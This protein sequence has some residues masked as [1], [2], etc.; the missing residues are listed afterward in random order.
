MVNR[1]INLTKSNSFFLFGPRQTGKSTLLQKQ[2]PE[3]TLN[4]NLLS[5][6]TY[7]RLAARPG[8][9]KEEIMAA[10]RERTI[11]HVII[12]EVQRIPALLDEVHSMLE[13]AEPCVF[14][15][16]GSSA[17]KLKRTH[18]NMLG[19]RAWTYRLFPLTTQEIGAGFNLERALH[20]GTLPKVYLA[21]TDMERSEILRSYV[22]TYIR[23]E[24]EIEAQIRNIGGF[25]RFLPTIASENGALVNFLNLSREL[26]LSVSTIRS[27]YQIMEDTLLGFFLSPMAK[28]ARKMAAGHPR[29]YLFDCGVVRALQKKLNAPLDEKTEEY[30]RAFEHFFICEIMRL[31]TYLRL[32]LDISFYRT[33]RGA[34]VDCIIKAP[35]G[36]LTA[37]EIKSTR[38][39]SPHHCSGLRS[40]REI[41]PDAKC[42]LACK[43]DKS[44][45]I[46]DVLALPWQEALEKIVS[47]K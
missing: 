45:V 24:I 5:T 46:G 19:G 47:L 23:E 14:G 10:R 13:S 28:S 26:M 35:S 11:T 38:N 41:Y 15:L 37:I 39:P 27:Y 4:Y 44:A 7:Q 31:N 9:L 29:F 2:F 20:F 17:R 22:D 30:G 1:Q 25:L 21:E 40:F 3:S 12:D 36:T 8:L 43:T 34:K 42:L 33:D 6:D 18:A 16:S 32:D